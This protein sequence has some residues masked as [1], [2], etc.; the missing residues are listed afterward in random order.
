MRLSVF[1]G[2]S[3]DGFLALCIPKTR[4]S[5]ILL[6]LNGRQDS[7]LMPCP[8]S[9]SRSFLRFAKDFELAH[10]CTLRFL[11]YGTRSWSSKDPVVVIASVWR[12]PIDCYGFGSYDCGVGGDPR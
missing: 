10:R 3:V 9:F 11:P 4:F 2:V 7:V 8:P 6:N 5:L 1:C 12:A